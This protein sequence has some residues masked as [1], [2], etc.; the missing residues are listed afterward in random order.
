MSA[1]P[2]DGPK[3]KARRAV[4]GGRLAVRTTAEALAYA[5]EHRLRPSRD[6]KVRAKLRI[7]RAALEGAG[8]RLDVRGSLPEAHEPYLVVANHRSV[9][10]IAALL[11]L[12]PDAVMLS[13]GDVEHWPALG[14]LAKEGNTLF[15]DR[16]DRSNGAKAIRA[17]RRVLGDGGHLCVFPEGTT[18]GDRTIRPFQAGAFAAARGMRA[19]IVPVGIAYVEGLEWTQKT[20]AE[21]LTNL[22]GRERLA[23]AIEIGAPIE[24]EGLR[25]EAVTALAHERVA[26]LFARA[27]A[28]IRG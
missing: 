11:A 9:F 27:T 4:R 20:I 7:G 13:R 1:R 16:Q 15:V 25:T 5:V 19:H 18:H 6:A 22:L 23:I 14:W 21:H 8:F 24:V 17:M 12:V 3:V 26:E 2:P 28:R 10:D